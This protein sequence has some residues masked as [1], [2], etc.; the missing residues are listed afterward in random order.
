M[1][2]VIG[3]LAALVGTDGS[4]LA[5]VFASAQAEVENNQLVTDQARYSEESPPGALSLKDA[6]RDPEFAALVEKDGVEAFKAL[7]RTCVQTSNDSC[8]SAGTQQQLDALDRYAAL[9]QQYEAEQLEFFRTE[10]FSL[11]AVG[12]GGL[13]NEDFIR[14]A[15]ATS[16]EEIA[17]IAWDYTQA[18]N[19]P[20]TYASEAATGF[21]GWWAQIYGTA[22]Y[23]GGEA[24][25][26][27]QS[28][29]L[30]TLLTGGPSGAGAAVVGGALDIFG[31]FAAGGVEG[32]I[33]QIFPSQSDMFADAQRQE[34]NAE[35]PFYQQVWSQEELNELASEEIISSLSLR[36]GTGL[37]RRAGLLRPAPRLQD[38]SPDELSYQRLIDGLNDLDVSTGPN[39]AV[40]YSGRGA[41]DAAEDFASSNGLNTLEQTTGGRYLDDL[42]LYENTVNNVRQS[43][44]DTIWG[45]ISQTYA[46]LAS[47][48]VNAIIS[49]PRSNS[50]FLTQE[51]PTLLQ[52]RNVTQ[53]TVRSLNGKQVTIPGG[54]P[55]DE[56]LKMLKGF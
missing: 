25:D 1:Q 47:G 14:L 11:I 50:V 45:R 41:R 9:N 44:A 13:S 48:K 20:A 34:N 28:D 32:Q 29:I 17:A 52:N 51:L 40:F 26:R 10:I 5:N 38:L 35:L 42:Q 19:P 27:A 53:V 24:G 55:I 54:T 36:P 39:Q 31:S 4:E 37:L 6:L 16:Q 30:N 3:G 18:N 7:L 8:A 33:D 49:N 56:A 15:T 21:E 22:L 46:S 12:S 43:Q 2:N 23:R